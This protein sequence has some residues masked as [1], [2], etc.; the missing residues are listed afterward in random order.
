MPIYNPVGV[1][2]MFVIGMN[3]LRQDK[4]PCHTDQAR[5]TSRLITIIR[6]SYGNLNA[7]PT[8]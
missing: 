6:P 5:V 8:T 1:Q 4:G 2:L 7:L 3:A